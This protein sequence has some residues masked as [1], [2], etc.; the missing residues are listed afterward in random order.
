[1]AR[2]RIVSTVAAISI[3]CVLLACDSGAQWSVSLSNAKNEFVYGRYGQL[4]RNGF[5]G[6]YD[7][8]ASSTAG[9][10]ASI[11]GWLGNRDDDIGTTASG[12]NASFSSV[13]LAAEPRFSSD[14]VS[15]VGRYTIRS[16]ETS[17]SSG[18]YVAMSPG[19]LTLWTIRANT[20]LGAFSWGKQEFV[21]GF[22]LQFASS[23]RV[24]ATAI[25]RCGFGM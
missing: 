23:T 15:A 12:T 4:G 6:T 5:F 25:N 22:G 3:G 18:S 9:A 2:V 20:P 7:I 24:S 13:S 21:R 14:W 8:D 11:N 10:F 19:Q 16:Y 1:M 17:R